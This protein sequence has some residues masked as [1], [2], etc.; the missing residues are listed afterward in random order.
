M[1]SFLFIEPFFA[2]ALVGH[3]GK[4]ALHDSDPQDFT[5]VNQLIT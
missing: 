5:V 3:L 1:H 2:I 4:H